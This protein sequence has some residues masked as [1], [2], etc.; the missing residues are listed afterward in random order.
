MSS[1]APWMMTRLRQR[2]IFVG[3]RHSYR[4]S[5]LQ[6]YGLKV[7]AT[8]KRLPLQSS[9]N[10]RKNWVYKDQSGGETGLDR[11]ILICLR[12]DAVG[13]VVGSTTNVTLL[14]SSIRARA[15]TIDVIELTEEQSFNTWSCDHGL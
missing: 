7:V 2:D 1:I 10:A 9:I 5:F 11:Y 12:I 13:P 6:P 14:Q 8:K 15:K 4:Q 3:R